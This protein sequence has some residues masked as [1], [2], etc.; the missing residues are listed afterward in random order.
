MTYGSPLILSHYFI[1]GVLNLY[2]II[3]HIPTFFFP[4]N[5][6]IIPIFLLGK[7][8]SSEEGYL[9]WDFIDRKCFSGSIYSAKS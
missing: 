1:K 5:L 9:P 3:I 7:A 6:L 8:S 4:T 2:S